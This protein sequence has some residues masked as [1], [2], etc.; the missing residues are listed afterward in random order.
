MTLKEL[1]RKI[2]NIEFI[3]EKQFKKELEKVI[4]KEQLKELLESQLFAKLDISEDEFKSKFTLLSELSLV[5][6]NKLSGTIDN[7]IISKVLKLRKLGLESEIESAIKKLVNTQQRHINTLTNTTQ[8]AISRAITIDKADEEDKFK[9]VG[10]QFNARSFCRTILN[11]TFT[12]SEIK[13]LNNG[14]NLP[15]EFYGGGYNCRHRW[16]KVKS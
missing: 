11:Q 13:D 14:Q 4:D 12:K 8:I 5:E 1:F 16:V 9:Y 6:I 3:N 2:K 10:S 7:K 15:V